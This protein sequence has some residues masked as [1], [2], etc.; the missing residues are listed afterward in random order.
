MKDAPRLAIDSYFQK[1]KEGFKKGF[2]LHPF[3]SSLSTSTEQQL[4]RSA[5][6]LLQSCEEMFH[7][8]T[9]FEGLP[10]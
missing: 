8:Q 9:W 2:V 3:P 6:N 1:I 10:M 4:T 5:V 7:G